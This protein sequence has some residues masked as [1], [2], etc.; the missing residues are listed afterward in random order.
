[1]AFI[2]MVSVRYTSARRA[3]IARRVFASESDTIPPDRRRQVRTDLPNPSYAELRIGR[4]ASVDV[5]RGFIMIVMALDH[6]RDFTNRNAMEALPTDLDATTP[7][8]F[9]TRWI[10][11]LCAPAFALTA[12]ASAWFWW[13][14]GRTRWA[15][16]KFLITRGVWLIVLE[17]TVMQLAYYFSWPS[18][19]PVLLLV[20]WSL[21]LS[22]ITLAFLIWLPAALIAL[23]CA[24]AILL[25]PLLD[26]VQAS[27]FGAVAGIWNIIHQVGAFSI[28]NTTIVAPYP[29]IPWAGVMALGFLLG[30]VFSAQATR[31]S[32]ILSELGAL[33]LAALL[34]LRA[35][36]GYGDPAP[37]TQHPDLLW[38]LM[39]F[40][41]V[42]KYP[43][44]PTFLLLTLGLI[45]LCLSVL[46]RWRFSFK[47]ENVF[48]VFG[49][50]PLFFYIL[51][52]YL[53]HL[54]STVLAIFIYGADA[55]RFAFQPYPSFGGPPAAFPADFG[56][57]LWVTYGAWLAVIAATYPLCRWYANIK[58]RRRLWWMSYL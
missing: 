2:D 39:S 22:M 42:S 38:T 40:L 8:I 23:L 48:E 35:R 13:K 58:F 9:F 32:I 41:N 53:A 43:A 49:R 52:F 45:F 55:A 4:I 5:L 47:L 44:S 17:L 46:E 12:G 28:G 50:V 57:S 30:P 27:D 3:D 25:H 15:L 11:H 6:V 26:A 20:L 37:W 36:N 54:L 21:G 31:R 24:A 51:H 56:Y 33:G 7:A 14:N 29:L 19:F 10:T 18:G 34:L 1:M 16:S